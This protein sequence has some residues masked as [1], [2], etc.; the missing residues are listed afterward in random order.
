[1]NILNHYRHAAGV[2]PQA[3]NNA[4]VTGDTIDTQGAT[5]VGVAVQAGAL[6]ASSAVT[7][8]VLESD[9]SASGFTAITGAELTFDGDDD[10]V[11]GL[12]RLKQPRHKRYLRVQIQN[13]A[14]TAA[15]IGASV[16]L[17]DR[18]KPA[19]QPGKFVNADTA[20]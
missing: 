10:N 14:A 19:A 15:I 13:T 9:E 17:D 7:V 5:E 18:E 2:P 6:P 4:T 8:R 12:I 11:P 3:V 20:I 16:L 1:M